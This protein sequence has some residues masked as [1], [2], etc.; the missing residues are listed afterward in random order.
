MPEPNETRC[1]TCGSD[2][3]AIRGCFS[4]FRRDHT[5]VLHGAAM[6]VCEDSWH[7]EPSPTPA[8]QQER[9]PKDYAI[10]FGEYL[11]KAVEHYFKERNRYDAAEDEEEYDT[12]A[13][14]DAWR[15]VHSALGEFRKRAIRA[16]ATPAARCPMCGSQDKNK[17]DVV[18]TPLDHSRCFHSWHD[19]ATPAAQGDERGGTCCCVVTR[20][21]W[22]NSRCP[23]HQGT[24]GFGMPLGNF[25]SGGPDAQAEVAHPTSDPS[26]SQRGG[27]LDTAGKSSPE[28]IPAQGDELTAEQPTSAGTKLTAF[29]NW[30]GKD[31]KYFD[32]D[33][34]DVSWFDKRKELAEYAWHRSK[35]FHAAA[36]AEERKGS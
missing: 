29:D 26:S 33:T 14:N 12:D 30:W 8:A 4:C 35:A 10:E 2:K 24:S 18:G 15:G 23:I 13:L 28:E 16:T 6:D 20:T 1:P 34:D 7:N 25:T 22:S 21:S 5:F 11:A 3:P 19:E 32:P 27:N 36:S 9:T 31:G 17:R